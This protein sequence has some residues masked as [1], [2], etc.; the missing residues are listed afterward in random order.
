[1]A[2]PVRGCGCSHVVVGVFA[3]RDAAAHAAGRWYAAWSATTNEEVGPMLSS[4]SESMIGAGEEWILVDADEEV[5][6]S[7]AELS[8]FAGKHA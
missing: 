3:Y 4:L 7:N 8:R 6:M 2:D 1:M 5:A